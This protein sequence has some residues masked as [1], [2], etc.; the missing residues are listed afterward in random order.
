MDAGQTFLSTT[1]QELFSKNKKIIQT[2]RLFWIN[3]DTSFFSLGPLLYSPV[4][5]TL[6]LKTLNLIFQVDDHG[7]EDANN[8]NEATLAD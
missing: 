1:L 3:P 4:A 6:A 5:L 2:H 7:L 8:Q